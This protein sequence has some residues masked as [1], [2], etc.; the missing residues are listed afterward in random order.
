MKET[1]ITKKLPFVIA[2]IGHNH[3]GSLEIAKKMIKEAHNCGA[4]C[5]QVTKRSNKKFVYKRNV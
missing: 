1:I 5:S 4:K 2:E 3:Q